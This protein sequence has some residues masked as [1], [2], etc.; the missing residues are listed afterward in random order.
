MKSLSIYDLS[1]A[2]AQFIAVGFLSGMRSLVYWFYFRC[3]INSLFLFC[4][5]CI[6]WLLYDLHPKGLWAYIYLCFT[7]LKPE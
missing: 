3:S 1:E 4:P 5:V 6:L 2:A 7:D